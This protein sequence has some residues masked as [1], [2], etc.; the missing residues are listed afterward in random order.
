MIADHG[1]DVSRLANPPQVLLL[2]TD[3]SVH[4]NTGEPNFNESAYFNFYDTNC[5]LG[6]FVRIGNRPNEGHAEMT[7][8]LFLPDGAVAFMF[9]RLEIHAND[10]LA[11]AGLRFEVV[12]P[13]EEQWIT[14]DG[15]CCMLARPLD[16]LEPRTAFMSN[17]HVPVQLEL[18]Y[19]CLSPAVGGEQTAQQVGADFARGH[20]E[21]HGRAIGRIN[22]DGT[23]YAIDGCGV[24]DRS[25][26]PR[27]WQ[28]LLCYRWLTMSFG[29]DAGIA[30]A[31]VVQRD[32]TEVHG[33]Y[34]YRMGEPNVAFDRI[35]IDTEYGDDGFHERLAVSLHRADGGPPE[36][37]DGRVMTMLP[38]RNRRHGTVTRITEGLT[39]WRWAGRTGYGWAEYLDH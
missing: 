38:L 22:I 14:Y 34:M 4:P 25:W 28:A 27:T 6:A 11:A 12:K 10:R 1:R 9:G 24:R 33:G 7:V 8:C 30:A 32:E 13:F 17:P 3:D 29:A 36:K 35:E 2:E 21:Q 39:E 18:R 37:I 23:E 5:R 31:L 15:T 19:R 20:F 26:G 16:M